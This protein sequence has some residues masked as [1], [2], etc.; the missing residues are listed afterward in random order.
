MKLRNLLFASRG[1]A[2]VE[3]ALAAPIAII[4]L[5]GIA[6]MGILFS[7]NAGLQHA[8]DEGARYATIYPRPSD[9][10]ITTVVNQ[11]RFKLDSNYVT[12]PVL[13]H[14]TTADGVAYLDITMTYAVPLNFVLFNS[15]P[16]TLTQTRR[17]FLY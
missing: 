15:P 2:I 16:I 5:I 9:T 12:A 17:T 1:A 11:Q 14:G 6:Q 10:A 7:A 3:F 8:V 13:T 4:L